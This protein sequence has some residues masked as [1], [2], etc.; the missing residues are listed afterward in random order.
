MSVR[1]ARFYCAVAV[2][3]AAGEKNAVQLL[4]RGVRWPVVLLAGLLYAFALGLALDLRRARLAAGSGPP[5]ADATL[6]ATH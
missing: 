1:R 6:L 5:P 3:S 4:V 2:A